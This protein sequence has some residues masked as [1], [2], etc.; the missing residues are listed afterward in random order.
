MNLARRRPWTNA[1]STE[2]LCTRILER[3]RASIRVQKPRLAVA[4]LARITGAT[5]ALSDK[6]S[7]H[8]T[9][10]RQLAEISGLRTGT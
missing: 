10:L 4:N 2:A 5:L 1:F 8:A 3:H 6:H 7:F 9:T